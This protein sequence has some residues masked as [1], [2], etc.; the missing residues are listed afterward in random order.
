LPVLAD[1]A[2]RATTRQLESLEAVVC[3]G[4]VLLRGER[5]PALP[6]ERFWGRRVLLP[7]GCRAD[8]ELADEVLAE[9]LGLQPGEVALLTG[10]G[11]EV[12][13]AEQFAPLSRAAVRRAVGE[14]G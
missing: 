10:A 14:A 9:A 13:A 4:R 8:P 11:V 12:V 5:L 6:G 7:L 1:W 2:D 3:T